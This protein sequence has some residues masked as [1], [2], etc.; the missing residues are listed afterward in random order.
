MPYRAE[1]ISG[2]CRSAGHPAP[3]SKQPPGQGALYV[4]EDNVTSCAM[5]AFI[6]GYCEISLIKSVSERRNYFEPGTDEYYNR[7]ANTSSAN[8]IGNDTGRTSRGIECYPAGTIELGERSFPK[9]KIPHQSHA[10]FCSTDTAGGLDN[11]KRRYAPRG[12]VAYR[13]FLW[14]FPKG[15][16]PPFGTRLCE[17][18]CSVLYAL[19]ALP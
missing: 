2:R 8:T 18:K 7:K 11:K 17:A 12:G 9:L 4:S 19:S 15:A 16:T 6:A 3:P 14:G 5:Q 1:R 13:L 10:D